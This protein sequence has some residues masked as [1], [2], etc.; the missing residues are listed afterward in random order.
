MHQKVSKI[1]NTFVLAT[2]TLVTHIHTLVHPLNSTYLTLL[3]KELV[4]T[5]TSTYKTNTMEGIRSIH[6]DTTAYQFFIRSTSNN[7]GNT[8][9]KG[10]LPLQ[11]TSTNI[12]NNRTNNYNNNNNNNNVTAMLRNNKLSTTSSPIKPTNDLRNIKKRAATSP[13]PAINSQNLK[14]KV[15]KISSIKA[16]EENVSPIKQQRHD[17]LI[18]AEKSSFIEQSPRAST[19]QLQNSTN[20][21]SNAYPL[22][23][24]L[25]IDE[26]ELHRQVYLME[27]RAKYYESLS[28]FLTLERQL[29]MEVAKTN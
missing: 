29:E 9:R 14:R 2:H 15:N 6:S 12:I 17:N 1:K 23:P 21:P 27:Q 19:G 25:S 7:N 24:P 20:Q 10:T 11:E 5:S 8:T 28:Q 18:I 3:E 22:W 13:T 16:D 26:V 4:E